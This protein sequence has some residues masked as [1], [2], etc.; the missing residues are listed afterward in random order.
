MA[1]EIAI[2]SINNHISSILSQLTRDQL[3]FIVALQEHRTKKDAAIS[4][5]IDP[6]ITYRWPAIVNEAAKLLSIETLE[7]A[8]EM[9]KKALTKAMNIKIE[10]LDSENERI[11]QDAATEIIEAELGRS[12][13]AIDLTSKGKGLQDRT[14]RLEELNNDELNILTKILAERSVTNISGG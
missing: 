9:R 6:I 13:Q 14:I 2:N 12:P 3:R 5:G 4:I 8:R 1:D 10:G 11:K 7:V